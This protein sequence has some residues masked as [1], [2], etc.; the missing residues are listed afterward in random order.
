MRLAVVQRIRRGD[1]VGFSEPMWL[2][3]HHVDDRY[4]EMLPRGETEI[5]AEEASEV[6]RILARMVSCQQNG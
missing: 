2:A 3:K 6:A 1:P 4:G 5:T